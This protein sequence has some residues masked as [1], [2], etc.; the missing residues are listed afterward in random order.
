MI[1]RERI[2]IKQSNEPSTYLVN[3]SIILFIDLS[4]KD[5]KTSNNT[6]SDN[7]PYLADVQLWNE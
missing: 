5:F 1:E 7:L 4:I 6:Y 3:T 2:R